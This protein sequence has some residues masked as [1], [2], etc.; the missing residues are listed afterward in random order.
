MLHHLGPGTAEPRHLPVLR[1]WQT[2]P[3][4]HTLLPANPGCSLRLLKMVA[5]GSIPGSLHWALEM[6]GICHPQANSLSSSSGV[7]LDFKFWLCESERPR[8]ARPPF[9]PS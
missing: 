5:P 4:N 9:S 7:R 8:L 3:I 6:K 1:L 2:L